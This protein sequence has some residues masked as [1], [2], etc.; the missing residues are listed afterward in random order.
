MSRKLWFVPQ[1]LQTCLCHRDLYQIRHHDLRG[2]QKDA[3]AV[4]LGVGI[5]GAKGLQRGAEDGGLSPAAGWEELPPASERIQQ[6]YLL[7]SHEQTNLLLRHAW[8]SISLLH[9]Q[10]W[11]RG[12]V[13]LR[14]AM[15][16]SLVHDACD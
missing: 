12:D 5:A 11:R 9:C 2:A 14:F 7:L 10:R 3:F 4:V 1:L 6:T 15:S 13:L 8:G 16:L